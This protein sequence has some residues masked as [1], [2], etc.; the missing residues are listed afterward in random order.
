MGHRSALKQ[1]RQAFLALQRCG[2]EILDTGF[3]PKQFL[4]HAIRELYEVFEKDDHE[5]CVVSDRRWKGAAGGTT[6]RDYRWIIACD[7]GVQLRRL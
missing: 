7:T 2:E 5:F 4:Q 6:F 3:R 1:S